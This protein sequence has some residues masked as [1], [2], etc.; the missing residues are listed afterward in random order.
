[1]TDSAETTKVL[2]INEEGQYLCGT[3]A[4]WEFT[5]D[6]ARARVFDY[7]EDHVSE[8]IQLVRHAYRAIWIAV[9]IDPSEAY[10]F[11]DQCG[12][13]M[14]SWEAFFNG[15]QFFCPNCNVTGE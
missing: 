8:Q 2:I 6:R 12:A 5:D 1:M 9:R 7:V 14:M 15:N 3:A 11:C 10:E 4:H 13:R